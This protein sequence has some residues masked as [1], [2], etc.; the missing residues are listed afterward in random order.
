[1]TDP[2]STALTVMGNGAS[3]A[4]TPKLREMLLAPLFKAYGNHW[5]KEAE[6]RLKQKRIEK[7][8]RNAQ[9]HVNALAMISLRRSFE[10]VADD[11]F[12]DEWVVGASAVDPEV[13]SDLADFW[14]AA[15]VSIAQGEA[16][17]VRLLRI[18]KSLGPDDAVF[19]AAGSRRG[20]L[21][22]PSSEFVLQS[23]YPKR[24]REAGVFVGFLDAL[25]QRQNFVLLFTS[26]IILFLL[27]YL[28][29]DFWILPV[30]TKEKLRAASLTMFLSVA[31][32]PPLYFTRFQL[33]SGWEL[34]QEGRRLLDHLAIVRSKVEDAAPAE[35]D[36][37]SFKEAVAPADM[38][39]KRKGPVEPSGLEEAADNSGETDKIQ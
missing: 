29:V 17:R 4:I 10:E 15:L 19:L 35:T 24:L 16:S 31:V 21:F 26:S 14:R 39:R 34:T 37:V 20:K 8:E 13:D 9:K 32:I 2:M 18:V 5:G 27:T 6:E 30:D 3:K 25:R 36:E 11:P 12:F 38:Q 28:T 1:M 7:R 33:Q 23:D 22:R